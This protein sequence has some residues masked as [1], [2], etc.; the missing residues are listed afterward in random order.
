MLALSQSRAEDDC[1][2]LPSILDLLSANCADADK[3]AS[4]TVAD[5]AYL[6]GL[7]A[8]NLVQIGSLQRSN[9]SEHMIRLFGGR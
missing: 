4:L 1:S 8:M 6:E 7:Y 5:K 2:Q 3:P 9:I